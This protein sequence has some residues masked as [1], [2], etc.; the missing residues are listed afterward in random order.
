H[1]LQGIVRPFSILYGNFASITAVPGNQLMV[2]FGH[3]VDRRQ[4]RMPY[5]VAGLVA[6]AASLLLVAGLQA[7]VESFILAS[8][9]FGLSIGAVRV[10][11][12]VILAESSHPSNRA[13]VMGTNH[14]MEHVGYGVAAILAGTLVAYVGGFVSAFRFLSLILLLAGLAFLLYSRKARVK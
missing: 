1:F 4:R 7:T 6:A 8:V 5:L 14:A 11:Q 12:L 2:P 3:F 10:G 9:T 13:A